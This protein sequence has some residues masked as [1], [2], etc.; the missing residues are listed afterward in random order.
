VRAL[1]QG[2]PAPLA[3]VL[4]ARTGVERTSSVR[5]AIVPYALEQLILASAREPPLALP[6]QREIVSLVR[7]GGLKKQCIEAM[8]KMGL[9][10]S[11]ETDM[12]TLGD[13]IHL[14]ETDSLVPPCPPPLSFLFSA[15]CSRSVP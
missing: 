5:A 2:D 10:A 15:L 11:V 4:D 13:G 7:H 12:Q 8:G 14:Q 9:A 1:S 3:P 6:F